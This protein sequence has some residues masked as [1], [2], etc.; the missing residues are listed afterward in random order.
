MSSS[1]LRVA[2]NKKYYISGKISF[3]VV[4]A[5]V[6]AAVVVVVVAA[7]VVVAVVVVVDNEMNIS[8][9]KRSPA[10]QRNSATR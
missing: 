10:K 7:A 9:P 2:K 5:A 3:V 6:V 1:A 8:S 4:A